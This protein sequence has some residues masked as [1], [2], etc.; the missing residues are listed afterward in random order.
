MATSTRIQVILSP[1][2]AETLQVLAKI[3]KRSVSNLGSRII[4]EY[5]ASPEVTENIKL[6]ELKAQITNEKI[7]GALEGANLSHDKL[8]R[9]TQ[10]LLTDEDG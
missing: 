6:A 5:L 2:V 4:E 3:E 8:L 10:I 1:E 9:L 7:R